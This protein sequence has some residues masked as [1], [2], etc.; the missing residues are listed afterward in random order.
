MN[1]WIIIGWIVLV[2]M[3]GFCLIVLIDFIQYYYG[4]KELEHKRLHDRTQSD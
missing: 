4:E 1:P 3:I 2:S